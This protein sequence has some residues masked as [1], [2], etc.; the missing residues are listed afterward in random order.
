MCKHYFIEKINYFL[1]TRRPE[2]LLVRDVPSI[3]CKY[4]I[5]SA[6]IGGGRHNTHVVFVAKLR[7]FLHYVF[8]KR[9]CE[10]FPYRF[11]RIPV[12][13][14]A[15][16]EEEERLASFPRY[17]LPYCP[18]LYPLLSLCA[19]SL[20]FCLSL[21]SFFMPQSAA[22][23]NMFLMSVPPSFVP[24]VLFTFTNSALWLSLVISANVHFN[25][26]AFDVPK[27]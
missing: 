8:M 1:A 5:S 20:P 12:R 9:R 18:L 26:I 10:P 22:R 14:T 16:E 25:S 15:E 24:G 17:P 6:R 4:Y 19:P 7:H 2:N 27:S 3:G 23:G 11:L 21:S 13:R